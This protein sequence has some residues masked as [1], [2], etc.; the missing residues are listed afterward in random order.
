M[1]VRKTFTYTVSRSTKTPPAGVAAELHESLNNLNRGDTASALQRVQAIL[2]NHPRHFDALHL[3]GLIAAKN[4]DP[5]TAIAHFGKALALKTDATALANRALAHNQLKQYAAALADCDAALALQPA[6]AATHCTRG[7]ALNGLRRHKDARAAF[8]RAQE[9]Q[10][11]HVEAWQQAG[12]LEL[13]LG[14]ARE[15]L[16]HYA[17]VL[18]LDAA[19]TE[20][21]TN[22]GVALSQLRR[23]DEALQCFERVIGL[24]PKH[25]DA[26]GNRGIALSELGRHQEALISFERAITLKPGY[27]E[28]RA[29]QG[30]CSL[31]TGDFARGWAQYEWRWNKRAADFVPAPGSAKVMLT[32]DNFGKPVWNGERT[33]ETVLIWPEQGIGDQ[34]LF[35]TMLPD[36]IARIGRVVLAIEE[37]L[38]P[39]F[40]RSFPQCTLTTLEAARKSGDF[41]LQIPLGNLGKHLRASEN[42]FL[43]NRKATLIADRSAAARLRKSLG[44]SPRRRLCGISWLSRHASF[45]T[46]KSLSLDALRP[47]LETP[48]YRFVDLQYGDTAK[49]RVAFERGTGLAIT[50]V[51]GIDNQ[52]D[53]DDLAALIEACDIIITISNTTAHIAGAL[54]K[55]VLLMLP[56]NTGRFWYW[57]ATREDTLW[58]PGVRVFRQ[59]VAGEWMAVIDQVGRA[60]AQHLPAPERRA[61]P[62]KRRPP[63][64][65]KKN[66][67]SN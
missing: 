30:V 14:R 12:N 27:I 43:L 4:R 6:S 9:L 44:A 25:A 51:D 42:T 16:D 63:A 60:L 17:Q 52:Q 3:L 67:K 7:R 29:N 28:A 54:G 15:A 58:Y 41:R 64:K 24:N 10:P 59:P 39:L 26:Y 61:T 48:G 37:R 49:E 1:A 38:H 65:A 23:H 8:A 18:A 32:P 45:G 21:L 57:Q 55:T 31:L 11:D 2:E 5:A 36:A 13:R 62:G 66:K 34:I 22:R 56:H 19:N 20:T 33:D 35:A 40:R 46:D 50:H 53:I 47:L